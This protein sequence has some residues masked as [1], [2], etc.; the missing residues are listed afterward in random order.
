MAL[1][2][3]AGRRGHL[4]HKHGVTGRGRSRSEES[5]RWFCQAEELGKGIPCRAKSLSKDKEASTGLASGG[6]TSSLSGR[7]ED[8]LEKGWEMGLQRWAARQSAT[9]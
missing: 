8:V 6:K 2:S 9:A 3:P 7:F 5:S 4:C 1:E